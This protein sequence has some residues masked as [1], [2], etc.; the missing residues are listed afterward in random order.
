MLRLQVCTTKPGVHP[1][2]R[3]PQVALSS[4][5][6]F[7]L[8]SPESVTSAYLVHLCPDSSHC[9]LK[10]LL[11]PFF[12]TGCLMSCV[13]IMS[14]MLK[15]VCLRSTACGSHRQGSVSL[16][17]YTTLYISHFLGFFLDRA[18]RRSSTFTPSPPRPVSFSLSLIWSHQQS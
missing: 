2:L 5:S 3:V 14:L 16:I 18:D 15:C 6:C 17:G 7:C 10:F 11:N 9:L 1:A 13:D 4:W 12:S 8:L